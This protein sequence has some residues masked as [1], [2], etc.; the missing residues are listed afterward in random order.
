VPILISD[1]RK[2]GIG[3]FSE[4]NCKNGK[5]GKIKQLDL[6]SKIFKKISF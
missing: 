3:K 5:F 4:K 1:G 2:N 6:M